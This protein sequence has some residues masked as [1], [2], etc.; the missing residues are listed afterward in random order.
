M[1]YRASGQAPPTT[2]PHPST[3]ADLESLVLGMTSFVEKASTHQG[4]E[5]PWSVQQIELDERIKQLI[6]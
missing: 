5:F 4:A 6:L 1:M 2:K 3:E